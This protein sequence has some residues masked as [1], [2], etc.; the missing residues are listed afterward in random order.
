MNGGQNLINFNRD[1]DMNG[2]FYSF[3]K[4]DKLCHD[5]LI[6]TSTMR[7]ASELIMMVMIFFAFMSFVFEY[8]KIRYI[9]L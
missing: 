8:I 3:C 6:I 9:D 1:K 7:M 2:D 4:S 5:G